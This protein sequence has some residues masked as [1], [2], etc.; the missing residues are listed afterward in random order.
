MLQS[1]K[2][3]C[4]VLV[5]AASCGWSFAK[6]YSWV[7]KP[8]LALYH[9]YDLWDSKYSVLIPTLKPTFDIFGI[10]PPCTIPDVLTWVLIWYLCPHLA[11]NSLPMSPTEI[12]EILM[13]H[14]VLT[15]SAGCLAW[16]TCVW[17]TDELLVSVLIHQGRD[18]ETEQ[19]LSWWYAP[20]KKFITT[21]W[22]K[23]RVLTYVLTCR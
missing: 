15:N 8:K 19:W 21:R 17:L 4:P 9:N 12:P 3:T 18:P 10:C 22:R 6:A 5:K 2:A 14:T 11:T 20:D 16:C 7:A 13:L 1:C 23:Q